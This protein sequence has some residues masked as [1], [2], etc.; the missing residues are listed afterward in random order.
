MPRPAINAFS[1]Q[2]V[3]A[4]RDAAN[5]T[6]APNADSDSNSRLESRIFRSTLAF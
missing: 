6:P 3:P 1:L 4:Q 2:Q 5:S